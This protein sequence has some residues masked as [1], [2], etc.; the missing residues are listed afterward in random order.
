MILVSS[1]RLYGFLSSALSQE[2]L[3]RP[4]IF[5]SPYCCPPMKMMPEQ[6]LSLLFFIFAI[7]PWLSSI[8][9]KTGV[10]PEDPWYAV[11]LYT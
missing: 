4:F 2:A 10:T 3:P 11:T 5:V 7:V 6:V 8:S 1:V 9:M